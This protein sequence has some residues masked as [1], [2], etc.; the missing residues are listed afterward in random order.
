MDEKIEIPI[1]E[2]WLGSMSMRLF[3]IITFLVSMALMPSGCGSRST[4]RR[5]EM[6]NLI[7]EIPAEER[8]SVQEDFLAE[9]LSLTPEQR[10]E[11][12]QINR[13]YA[14]EVDSILL[15]DDWRSKKARRFKSAM[16][17]KDR[18]LKKVFSKEQYKM[19]GQI[20]EELKQRLRERR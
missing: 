15:S 6:K 20:R 9:A 16:R 4:S 12:G 14:R 8:S 3:C 17:N 13:K 18:E 19:Y 7:Q 10:E 2:Q 1:S 11:V 5:S